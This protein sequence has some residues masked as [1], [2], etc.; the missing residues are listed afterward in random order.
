MDPETVRSPRRPRAAQLGVQSSHPAIFASSASSPWPK[1]LAR[2]V[3][4]PDMP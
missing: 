4:W 1:R 3:C 2:P